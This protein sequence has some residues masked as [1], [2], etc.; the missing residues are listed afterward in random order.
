MLRRQ[1]RAE[2]CVWFRFECDAQW[3]HN[4]IH[5]YGIVALSADRRRIAVLAATDTD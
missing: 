5:D 2:Q 1:R 3:F 4:E